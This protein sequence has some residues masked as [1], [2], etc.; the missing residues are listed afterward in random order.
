MSEPKSLTVTQCHA[1]LD[2]VLIHQGTPRAFKRGIRNYTIAL[3][4]LEAGLRVNEVVQLKVEDLWFIDQPVSELLV[5]SDI[6]KNKKERRIPISSRLADA[7]TECQVKV[8]L[9]DQVPNSAYAFYLNKWTMHISTR[10]VQR[11]MMQAAKLARIKRVTP[12]M[13]RHTFATRVLAKSNLRVTQKLLGHSSVLSTQIYTH[14]NS[15]DLRKA[16]E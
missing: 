13:L 15:D 6:A 11:F 10:Q 2:E 9:A 7:I 4:C 14:P 8:W 12:H 3:L 5:R 1:L 16:V